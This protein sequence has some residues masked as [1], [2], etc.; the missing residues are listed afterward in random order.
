MQKASN[1]ADNEVIDYANELDSTLVSPNRAVVFLI[2]WFLGLAIPAL[3]IF[4]LDS[5]NKTV[6]T[7]DINRIAYMPVAGKIPRSPYKTSTVVLENP[8][9]GV[10]EAFRILRSK[11]QFFTKEAKSPVIL[12]T[13]ALP[14][15]G[16]TFTA[17]NL[18]S[19]YSLL[20]KKTVLLGFDLRKPKIFDD[21]DLDNDSGISTFLI[22]KDKFQDVVKATKF[23]NLFIIPAG[24]VPPNPSELTSLPKTEELLIMLRKHYDCIIIDSSPIG[25]VSD[26][27]HLAS[28]ADLCLLVVRYEKTLKDVLEKTVNELKTSDIKSISLV[29]NDLPFDEKHY[30]YGGR[31]GYIKN[32]EKNKDKIIGTKIFNKDKEK[33]QNIKVESSDTQWHSKI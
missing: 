28:L 1:I 9:S 23:E 4:L 18:A 31:Y 29:I 11:M 6:K 26:T 32:P 17:I 30:G 10:A 27:Y 19:V 14:E 16:K 33:S 2:A 20:G 22:G 3:V 7:E 13:S 8:E 15:D 24:P 5:L 21:F 12:L 25:L